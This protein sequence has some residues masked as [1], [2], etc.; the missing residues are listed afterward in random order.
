MD[1]PYCAIDISPESGK[2]KIFTTAIDKGTPESLKRGGVTADF[3]VK[4]FTDGIHA[5]FKC[6]ISIGNLYSFYTELQE[7]YHSLKG[8]ATLKDYSGKRTNVSV[9]FNPTGYCVVHGFVQNGSYSENRISFSMECDQTYICST[10]KKLAM[11]FDEL[12][13]IQGF[14]EFPY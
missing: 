8:T 3:N 6:G 5:D 1:F 9:D 14:Y 12:A 2:F 7:C 13:T 11:L 4:I 10:V